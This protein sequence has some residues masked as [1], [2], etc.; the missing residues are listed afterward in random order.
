MISYEEAINKIQLASEPISSHKL[1]LQKT[2]GYMSAKEV[3]SPIEI[4][5]FHNSAMD[6]FA[7][8]SEDLQEDEGSEPVSFQVVG[9]VKAGDAIS[10]P[11]VVKKNTTY[12]I[13]TGAPI[14]R[15]YDTVVRVEDVTQKKN[16]QQVEISINKII[17]CGENI[18]RAGEDFSIADVIL[19]PG[20]MITPSHIM[21]LAAVGISE[22]TVKKIPNVAVF[23]TGDELLSDVSQSMKSGM[24]YNS[25]GP[26]IQSLLPSFN[27]NLCH[28]EVLSDCKEGFINKMNELL[29]SHSPPDVILTSGGVSVGEY[30]FIPKALEEM[31]ADVIFH[32]VRIRPG[33]PV[34]FAK[35]NQCFILGLPGNPVSTAVGLRFFLY[36]LLRNILMMGA[37]TSVKAKLIN[38]AKTNGDLLYFYKAVLSTN[39]DGQSN[40]EVLSGQESF[41]IKPLIRANC[42]AVSN[43][44]KGGFTSGEIIDVYP[45]YPGMN[46]S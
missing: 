25:N 41:K 36:P 16:D 31:G 22:V 5:Q 7:I 45:F 15:G 29:E 46:R 14:P 35:I 12:S 2:L 20:M 23:C 4:P 26:Y 6:G 13:M 10:S 34:L 42:W 40:V 8:R 27:A 11:A 24:I 28:Y 33:K 44:I 37:E 21:A 17:S 30:D 18:R 39:S 38:S 1:A 3:R 19:R 9:H 43:A 32:K